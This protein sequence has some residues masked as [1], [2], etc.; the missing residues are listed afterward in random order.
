MDSITSLVVLI[1]TIAFIVAWCGTG[2]R[3]NYIGLQIALAFYFVAFEGFGPPTELAPA[4]DRF[5]GIIVAL[6]VMWFIF[7]QIWPV[8][9]L[10]IM[11]R[12]LASVLRSDTSLLQ[13]GEAGQP[14][15]EELRQA[16]ALRDQVGKTVAGLRT[17]N[18]AVE[19]EFGVDREI[20][21]HSSHA[22]LRAAF[23]AV[24]MFWN[25]LVVLHSVED[26]DFLHEPRLIEMRRAFAAELNTMADGAAQKGTYKPAL[27]SSFPDMSILDHPR[28]GEYVRNTV[29]RF[30]ELQGIVS[31]LNGES[32]A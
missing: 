21:L 15:S 1:T 5:V 8:R 27:A 13:L 20:H 6:V 11:R 26:E 24:A 10:T 22:I 17:M 28:Y 29:N 31:S 30:G 12:D 7:D 25:Q 2:R 23:S 14:R 3:F 16:N 32:S 19:Y 9:T 4:R 18:D